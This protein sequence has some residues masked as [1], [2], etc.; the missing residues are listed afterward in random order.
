MKTQTKIALGVVGLLV[1]AGVGVAIYYASSTPS[2]KPKPT[3][4]PTPT[5]GPKPEPVDNCVYVKA[6]ENP[7]TGYTCSAKQYEGCE[8]RCCKQ[9]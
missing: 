4:T 1:I 2:P 3:P 7:P 9:E 6:Y 8:V 5:P